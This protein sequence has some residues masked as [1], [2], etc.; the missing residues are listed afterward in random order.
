MPIFNPTEPHNGITVDADFLRDQFNS[1][2]GQIDAIPAGPPGP[3]GPQGPPGGTNPEADPVFT[4][5]EAAQLVP[6]DK[7]KLDNAVQPGS[8]VSALVNDAKYLVNPMSTNA[9]G[10]MVYT[11]WSD[12][13]PGAVM[14]ARLP[15]GAAGQILSAVPGWQNGT[16]VFPGWI[17][18]ASITAY[19]P[20]NPGYW[21]SPP[22]SLAE[23][24]D[25]LAALASNNG[26]NPIP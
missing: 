3:Q 5:S 22:A 2:K 8:N 20:A 14:N 1:L 7:A 11:M 4:A 19:S 21:A 26:A 9:P 16:G 15:I 23:A 6:G 10:D 25:R 24:I 13:S 18:P 17:D 12:S